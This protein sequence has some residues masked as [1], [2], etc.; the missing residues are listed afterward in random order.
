MFTTTWNHFTRNFLALA[1]GH[2]QPCPCLVPQALP[3]HLQ[4]HRC[5]AGCGRSLEAQLK[6][7]RRISCRSAAEHR[8]RQSK[9]PQHGAPSV[10]GT[11]P[12]LCNAQLCRPGSCEERR[13]GSFKGTCSLTKDV[14]GPG[15]QPREACAD[16]SNCM[17]EMGKCRDASL[18]ALLYLYQKLLCN[19]SI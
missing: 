6:D 5:V 7:L 3:I 2:R 4:L 11:G 19:K 14:P 9:E 18:G 15:A 10:L 16:A 8:L 12:A 17:G 1:P 13:L